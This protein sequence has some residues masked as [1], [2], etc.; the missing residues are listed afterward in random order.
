MPVCGCASPAPSPL[1][2][3][4]RFL[5]SWERQ[6]CRS[7]CPELTHCGLPLL[8]PPPDVHL[9]PWQMRPRSKNYNRPQENNRRGVLLLFSWVLHTSLTNSSFSD[10][11]K[12]PQVFCKIPRQRGLPAAP[13]TTHPR[14]KFFPARRNGGSS[15]SLRAPDGASGSLGGSPAAGS[16]LSTLGA[17]PAE[18]AGRLTA[19]SPRRG[20]DSPASQPRI[21]TPHSPGLEIRHRARVDGKDSGTRAAPG[22]GGKLRQSR[23]YRGTRWCRSGRSCLHRRPSPPAARRVLTRRPRKARPVCRSRSPAPAW[24]VPAGSGSPAAPPLIPRAGRG[25][26]GATR[27]PHATRGQPAPPAQGRAAAAQSPARASPGPS[28]PSRR[29]R[30]PSAARPRCAGASSGA[31]TRLTRRSRAPAPGGGTR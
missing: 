17:S 27:W 23:R 7:P 6:R 24:W 26:P 2:F 11:T 16:G 15:P 29:H 25:A 9:Q 28:I 10:K 19:V 21:P 14:E 31:A 5:L 4:P 12:I 13:V 22:E 30:V 1:P 20:A 3:S 18:A 8:L